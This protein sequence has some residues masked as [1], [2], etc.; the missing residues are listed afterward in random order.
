MSLSSLLSLCLLAAA[1]GLV[2]SPLRAAAAVRTPAPSMKGLLGGEKA[3]PLDILGLGPRGSTDS[4]SYQVK[5]YEEGSDF[6]FFQSPGPK[7]AIQVRKHLRPGSRLDRARLTVLPPRS[8]G[9]TSQS[10]FS[11]TQD[12]LPPLGSD[13]QLQGPLQ[14]GVTVTGL[15]AFALLVPVF[16]TAEYPWKEFTL[17]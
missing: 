7:T 15:A 6:L 1:N 13:I 17:P 2:V 5:A 8:I 11:S 9:C 4:T 16:F 14:I 3:N 10:L 12:D